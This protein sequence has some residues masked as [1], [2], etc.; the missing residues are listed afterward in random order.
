MTPQRGNCRAPR[1]ERRKE[2]R[3]ER[4]EERGEEEGRRG[5]ERRG[6]KEGEERKGGR[7][8]RESQASWK[9]LSRLVC[10]PRSEAVSLD[11]TTKSGRERERKRKR[12]REREKEREKERERERERA[13]PG[14]RA[15]RMQAILLWQ[16]LLTKQCAART[17]GDLSHHSAHER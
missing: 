8:A 5:E 12:K 15:T 6:E 1:E 7:K 4:R 2:R 16:P 13:Q 9:D 14:R 3:G 17:Y 10:A 11:V